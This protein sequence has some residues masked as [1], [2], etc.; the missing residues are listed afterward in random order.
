[1]PTTLV[2]CLCQIND[3]LDVQGLHHRTP[4]PLQIETSETH[5]QSKPFLF[6]IALMRAYNCSWC[7]F[8]MYFFQGIFL[9]ATWRDTGIEASFHFGSVCVWMRECWLLWSVQLSVHLSVCLSVRYHVARHFLQN[10]LAINFSF[11]IQR[12]ISR[13]ICA[14]TSG[15]PAVQCVFTSTVCVD[16]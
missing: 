15:T 11:R 8:H 7:V 2:S 13:C 6:G 1:M 5:L 16:A 12:I 4:I 3:R 14:P 9:C 10:C